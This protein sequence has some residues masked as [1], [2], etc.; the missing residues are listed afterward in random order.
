M[1]TLK[2]AR[3]L[4]LHAKCFRW[5]DIKKVEPVIE[6][7]WK[8]KC[9][10]VVWA[11]KRR[12]FLTQSSWG[13]NKIRGSQWFVW[14]FMSTVIEELNLHFW[15]GYT[16]FIAVTP[17]TTNEAGGTDLD[18][19]PAACHCLRLTA[20]LSVWSLLSE[21]N[22][23]TLLVS[24]A[25]AHL[26]APC[27]TYDQNQ[28]GNVQLTKQCYLCNCYCISEPELDRWIPFPVRCRIASRLRSAMWSHRH[29][30]ASVCTFSKHKATDLAPQRETP[31]PPTPPSPS[32]LS[33]SVYLSL[34]Q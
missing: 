21:N 14:I 26:S 15:D 27:G 11:N 33:V 3:Y 20:S 17:K 4:H 12:L 18:A 29:T 6:F 23:K 5:Q 2:P 13:E 9:H 30:C 19:F 24:S 22:R 10:L 25:A 34:S 1:F 28:F 32:H 16:S 8:K 7:G 31:P